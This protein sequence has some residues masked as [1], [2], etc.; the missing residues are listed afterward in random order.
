MPRGQRPKPTAIQIVEGDP[1]RLG[2]NKLQEKAAHEPQPSEGLPKCPVHLR[3]YARG[4]W[5]RWR[6]QLQGMDLDRAPD[7]QAPLA[8]RVSAQLRLARAL[9]AW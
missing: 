5:Y 6:K 9:R 7:A 3:G 1:R 4:A 2:K 8:G